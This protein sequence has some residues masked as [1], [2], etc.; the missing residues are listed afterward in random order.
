MSPRIVI[1]GAGGFG[2]GVEAW[3]WGSHRAG[4]GPPTVFI[5]DEARK[6]SERSPIVGSIDLYVPE[7]DD[8]V[9]VAVGLPEIRRRLVDQLRER[10]AKF[11]TFVDASATLGARVRVGEGSVICPGTVVSSD[12]TIGSHTHINF[13]CSIGHDVRV[14]DF[15][16]LSPSVN[17]M[18]ESVVGD[19]AFFGGSSALLPRLQVGSGAIVGAGA[20][21]H[22]DVASDTTVVGNPARPVWRGL[23][24]DVALDDSPS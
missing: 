24:Q 12:V 10:G 5:D 17:L 21:A 1:A 19:L 23:R 16:T 15:V 7:P 22:R 18:G 6:V 13:N 8:E 3:I 14:G 11:H 9:I 2:R 4:G 20:L